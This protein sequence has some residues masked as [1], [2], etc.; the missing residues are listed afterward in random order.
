MHA[1][2]CRASV[3]HGVRFKMMKRMMKPVLIVAALHLAVSL[4]A[5]I[6]L[7]GPIIPAPADT[8]LHRNAFLDALCLVLLSPIVVIGMIVQ[9][10]TNYG[11]FLGD[12]FFPPNLGTFYFPT[13]SLAQA[14][15]II[16]LIQKLKKRKTE[17]VVRQVSAEAV[18]S[19]SLPEPSI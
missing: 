4:I 12:I 5:T 1:M 7:L 14:L 19:A 13:N 17:P 10:S 11:Y 18:P 3:I 8:V 9:N 2:R 15:C 16:W 6:H